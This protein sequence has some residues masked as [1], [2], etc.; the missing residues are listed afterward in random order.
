MANRISYI[1]FAIIIGLTGCQNQ[2]KKV[3][4]AASELQFYYSETAVPPETYRVVK[5]DT[6]SVTRNMFTDVNA[7]IHES[8]R[9]KAANAHADAVIVGEV[10]RSQCPCPSCRADGG[11]NGGP[12]VMVDIVLLQKCD[13]KR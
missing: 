2:A 4:A 13:N 3:P 9:R 10:G 11:S 6:I 8:I 12:H 5:K 1:V 7:K